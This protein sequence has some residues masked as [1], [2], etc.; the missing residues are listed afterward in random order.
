M[1]VEGSQGEELMF[2]QRA[3]VQPWQ[4]G[5]SGMVLSEA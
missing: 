3:N 2:N 4:A 1:P 5:E